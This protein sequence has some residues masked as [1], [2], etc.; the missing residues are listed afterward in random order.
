M[1]KA[2][3]VFAAV[4]RHQSEWDSRSLESS[5]VIAWT[6]GKILE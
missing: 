2:L 5:L 4:D 1:S 6:P 3:V